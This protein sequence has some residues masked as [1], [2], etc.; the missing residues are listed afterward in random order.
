MLRMAFKQENY[1]LRG[2]GCV[3]V[4]DLFFYPEFLS[5]Y[6]NSHIA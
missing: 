4:T 5:A 1:D 2:I 3:G 6:E